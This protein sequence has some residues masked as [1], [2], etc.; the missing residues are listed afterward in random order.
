MPE[1]Y[2]SPMFPVQ[3]AKDTTAYDCLDTKGITLDSFDG[4]TIVRVRADALTRLSEKAFRTVATSTAP[5]IWNSS[6][7]SWMTRKAV[8]TTV[9]WRSKC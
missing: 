8:K 3:T 6:P 7:K 5:P 9:L 4:K 2:F 1:F